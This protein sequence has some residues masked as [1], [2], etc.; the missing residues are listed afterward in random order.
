MKGFNSNCK[1]LAV[2]RDYDH[3]IRPSLLARA[4][5]T[6][7]SHNVSNSCIV[8]RSERLVVVVMKIV[9]MV[10]G[11]SIALCFFL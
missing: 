3:T 7:I 6:I 9:P 5:L 4:G 2:Y 11:L 8:P 10:F 1:T